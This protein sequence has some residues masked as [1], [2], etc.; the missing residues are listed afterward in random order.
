MN[1]TGSCCVCHSSLCIVIRKQSNID[2]KTV[3]KVKTKAK[4]IS[5]RYLHKFQ[6]GLGRKNELKVSA[7]G[8]ENKI[9]ISHLLF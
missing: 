7:L 6:G 3:T 9:R 2:Y 1:D 8:F 4:N 5:S